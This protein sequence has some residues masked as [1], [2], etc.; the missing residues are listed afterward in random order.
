MGKYNLLPWLFC[1]VALF[2]VPSWGFRF[3]V[4]T[5][6]PRG[7]RW[8]VR[9]QSVSGDK[10]TETETERVDES[11]SPS[12]SLS[13]RREML[14]GGPGKT[15]LFSSFSL[16]LLM[17]PVLGTVS[18]PSPTLAEGVKEPESSYLVEGKFA[19]K[20][21]PKGYRVVKLEEREVQTAN[22]EKSVLVL[23]VIYGND[24]A[25]I[26]EGPTWVAPGLFFDEEGGLV[27]ISASS[28]AKDREAKVKEWKEQKGGRVLFDFSG[29][30]KRKGPFNLR[31][32]LQSNNNLLFLD[33]GNEWIF[34]PFK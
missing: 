11:G 21:H 24:N 20:F 4:G 13:S 7:R 28:S 31:A 27:S 5:G 1:L 19:D 14:V 12:I 17:L 26:E 34:K 30:L 2:L 10:E 29:K 32:E 6:R 9:V 3:G 22:G 23:P 25:G 33:D 15:G 16:P 18:Q 8:G